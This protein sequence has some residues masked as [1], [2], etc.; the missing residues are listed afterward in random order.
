MLSAAQTAFTELRVRVRSQP[1]MCRSTDQEPSRDLWDWFLNEHMSPGCD[2][3]TGRA[4]PVTSGRSR[5]GRGLRPAVC[6]NSVSEEQLAIQFSRAVAAAK[7]LQSCPTVCGPINGSP[8]GSSVHGILEA[9]VLEWVAISFS[10]FHM[11]MCEI[12]KGGLIF[13]FQTL[14][15]PNKS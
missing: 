9:R 1:L 12:V 10:H 15:G 6:L 11:K 13:F 7:S 8:P 5:L 14:I 3:D 2:P 4:Q